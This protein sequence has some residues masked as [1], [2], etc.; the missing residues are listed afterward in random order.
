MR[1]K[2]FR[3][4]KVSIDKNQA[5]YKCNYDQRLERGKL[6][7]SFKSGDLV[8]YI[9]YRKRDRMGGKFEPNFFPENDVCVVV[10]V[11]GRGARLLLRDRFGVVVAKPISHCVRRGETCRVSKAV[12]EK[13]QRQLNSV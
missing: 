3:S 8:Q 2:L 1:E 11:L 7:V 9:N 5:R 6:L 12:F 13:S 10:K 4:A